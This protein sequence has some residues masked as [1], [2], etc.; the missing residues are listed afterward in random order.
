MSSSSAWSYSGQPA[1]W[2]AERPEGWMAERAEFAVLLW[3]FEGEGYVVELKDGRDE[4]FLL[5]QLLQ[6]NT[7]VLHSF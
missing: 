6:I 3:D 4:C 2:I 7:D 1:T 5:A